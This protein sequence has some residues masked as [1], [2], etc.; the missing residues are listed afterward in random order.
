[1]F[2]HYRT[3]GIFIKRREMGEADIL[4]TVYTQ[5][6]GK[7]NILGKAIR[8]I[9]SKLRAG[10]REFCFSEIEFIQGKTNKTLTDAVL[11]DNFSEIRK[12]LDKTDTAFKICDVLDQLVGQEEKDN[13]IW[14]L[15]LESFRKLEIGNSLKSNPPGSLPKSIQENCKLKIIY[16]FFL[17]NL[18]AILGYCP[19][20]YKC[21]VCEKKL[22]PDD[23]YFSTEQG[24][25][26]CNACSKENYNSIEAETIK[27]LRLILSKDWNTLTKL[28]TEERNWQELETISQKYIF[29]L[30]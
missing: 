20:L 3:K 1:M 4:F 15:L 29:E 25:L 28:K 14:E 12:D 11:I 16:Y 18:L 6:F 2:I 10:A 8:K 26:V 21:S 27:I 22:Y 30:K 9:N 23:L 24:G 13:Q 19:E 7:L 17:W 5:D